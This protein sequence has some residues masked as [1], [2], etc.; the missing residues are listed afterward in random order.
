MTF[1]LDTHL[2]L[3]TSFR[4]SRLPDTA[5][6]LLNDRDNQLV[7]SV[8][9]LWEVAIKFG[10]GRPDFRVDPKILRKGLIDAGYRELT[11]VSDHAFATGILP[12]IHRA[13]FDRILIAQATVEAITLLTV[14]PVVAQYP[15]PIRLV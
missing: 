2:L 13:P 9:S 11:I 6:D 3:W 10:L 15:G 1:L 14:D 8:S 12:P 7:F 5:K 4:S